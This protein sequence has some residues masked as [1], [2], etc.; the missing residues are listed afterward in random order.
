M[1]VYAGV[2]GKQLKVK[3]WQEK[4]IKCPKVLDSKGLE[5][6]WS[7]KTRK[8]RLGVRFLISQCAPVGLGSFFLCQ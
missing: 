7:T 8:V 4:V 5:M 3:K 1:I 2:E 6:L